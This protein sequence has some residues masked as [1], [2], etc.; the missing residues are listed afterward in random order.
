MSKLI[1]VCGLSG[2]GKTTLARALSKKLNIVCLHKDLIKENLYEAMKGNTLEDSKRIGSYTAQLMLKV[3][4]E[5]L[6]NGV[7]LMLE[8]PFNFA[9]DE[10][11]F[12]EWERKYKLEIFTIVCE[13]DEDEREH[14]YRDR[15]RHHAH[16]DSER[17]YPTSNYDYNL[18]PGKKINLITKQSVDELVKKVI[19]IIRSEN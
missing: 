4:E 11:V 13:I 5:Y 17:N 12:K 15:K 14:R 10:K 18:L 8:S 19:S 7:D 16:H 2:S 6:S 9:G 1:I 3:P